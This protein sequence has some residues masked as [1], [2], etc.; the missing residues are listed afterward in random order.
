MKIFITGSTG[1][2]GKNLSEFYS[3]NHDVYNY[4]R[5]GLLYAL[6]Y[7]KPDVIINCAAEIYDP[8]VMFES[9]ILLTKTCLDY[10]KQHKN[11]MIQL[12][13]SS[14]LGRIKKPGSEIDMINPENMYAGT[15]GAATLL[16]QSYAREFNLDIA[17][18]RPYSVYGRYERSRRLFPTLRNALETGS[19]IKLSGGYHDWIYIDDFVRGINWMVGRNNEKGDIFHFGTG[20]QESNH[21]VLDLFINY[22]YALGIDV[23]PADIEEDIEQ[24]HNYDTDMWA[25]D[26]TKTTGRGFK[27]EF[28][29]KQGIIHYLNGSI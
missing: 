21:T 13:S 23:P 9:N 15:K 8:N 14:E 24:Y 4:S 17:I 6:N 11:K 1:F 3:I 25:C 22:Y 5:E 18:A 2:I 10:I 16:C 20:V 12:G 7:F 29:L 19:K 28:T 26:I 27:T